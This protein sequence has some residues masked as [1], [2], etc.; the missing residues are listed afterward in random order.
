[1][2]HTS[3]AEKALRQNIVRRDR[4]R[5]TRKGVKRQLKALNEAIVKGTPEQ[6]NKELALA[7]KR[8]DKAAKKGVLHKNTAARRKSQLARM[9][10]EKQKAAK[11]G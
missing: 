11:P 4:N 6:M 9:V 5:V 10:N 1:M 2:P 3:S 7:M 8:I